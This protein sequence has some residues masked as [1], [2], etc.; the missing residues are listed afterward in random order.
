MKKE[1]NKYSE[2]FSDYVQ[3]KYSIMGAGAFLVAMLVAGPVLGKLGYTSL[4]T[5]NEIPNE[6]TSAEDSTGSEIQNPSEKGVIPE[7]EGVL[8]DEEGDIFND[9]N[10]EK[11]SE[12]NNEGDSN[13]SIDENFKQI[14]EEYSE[15]TQED[16]WVEP[17]NDQENNNNFKPQGM[18]PNQGSDEV[19]GTDGKTYSNEEAAQSVKVE[20]Q[21]DGPCGKSGDR[22]IRDMTRMMKNWKF[23][24][25]RT[26]KNATKSLKK[27]GKMIEYLE[28]AELKDKEDSASDEFSKFIQTRIDELKTAETQINANIKKAQEYETLA[29]NFKKELESRLE[30]V[31]SGEREGQYFWNYNNKGDAFWVLNESLDRSNDRYMNDGYY[32][33]Y[34]DFIKQRH[35]AEKQG[36]AD[37]IDWSA[38]NEIIAYFVEHFGKIDALIKQMDE[39]VT[40]AMNLIQ[41]ADI[42]QDDAEDMR[43]EMR[44]IMDEARDQFNEVWEADR[45]FWDSEPWKQIEEIWQQINSVRE[46]GMATNEIENVM[47][48]VAQAKEVT[49]LLQGIMK[50]EKAQAIISDLLN[51]IAKVEEGAKK[52]Q[53]LAAKGNK[54]EIIWK[55]LEKVM[56]PVGRKVE[57]QI[58]YLADLYFRKYEESVSGEEKTLIEN[59]FKGE[60][61][62]DPREMMKD[63]DFE[64]KDAKDHLLDEMGDDMS[65]GTVEKI[66]KG[67][68]SDI[69]ESLSNYDKK[70]DINLGSTLEM[71]G[72]ADEENFKNMLNEKDK[73]AEIVM[74]L[75]EEMKQL[76]IQNKKLQAQLSEIVQYNLYG[77]DDF[78]AELKKV[79]I[80]NLSEQEAEALKQKFEEAK[81]VSINAKFKDGLI[82]FKDV[83][84]DQWYT[85]FVAEMKELGIVKGYN[86]SEYRPENAV[87]NAEFTK[88]LLKSTGR[89]ESEG[90]P[91]NKL[92]RNHWAKGF[93]ETAEKEGFSI[94]KTTP[95]DQASRCM[96]AESI[97]EALDLEQATYGGEFVDLPSSDSCAP[98]IATVKEYGIMS[99]DSNGATF[100]PYEGLNRAEV[101]KVIQKVLE[102]TEENNLH[103]FS[104]EELTQSA[105]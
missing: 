103:N 44:D 66:V 31:R 74:Q 57:P 72:F 64:D 15:N 38:Q 89:D 11:P 25:S 83:D 67:I 62:R 78:Q 101:A 34:K 55:F 79:N 65:S 3:K 60:M 99:G 104:I 75:Q 4:V 6:P 98:Y 22:E 51:L 61:R 27:V 12:T 93:Y 96:V 54:P 87:T 92:A 82:P 47:Q 39:A 49:T 35:E 16:G 86:P 95:D 88:I 105:Q 29:Q 63:I 102:V 84:D 97:V 5:Q 45:E 59:F 14:P 73:L 19:C 36:V 24:F 46:G 33:F 85:R 18:E 21:H 2:N 70:M 26:V 56:D 80:E 71:G 58:Q 90:E 7:V 32:D 91:G 77:A 81:K 10:T 20:V 40:L 69:L 76:K 23:E 52:A 13:N 37:K 48:E 28:K 1:K 41:D 53:A 50:E 8:P 9:E 94:A 100:R 17:S 43:Q 42:S 68:Q 30:A